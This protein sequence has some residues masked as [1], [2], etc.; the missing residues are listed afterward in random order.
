MNYIASASTRNKLAEF[1]DR[2]DSFLHSNI[3]LTNPRSVGVDSINGTT[4]HEYEN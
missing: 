4:F 3:T 1:D 2:D